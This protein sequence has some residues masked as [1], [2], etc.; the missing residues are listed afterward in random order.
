[1]SSSSTRRRN[2]RG[3]KKRNASSDLRSFRKALSSQVPPSLSP[4][5]HT[6]YCEAIH[7]YTPL[8]STA[9][10]ASVTFTFNS[11]SL[12][13][14]ATASPIYSP[15]LAALGRVFEKFRVVAY[16]YKIEVIARAATGDGITII[17]NNAVTDYQTSSGNGANTVT[18][19]DPRT[20][21]FCV[22]AI[23]KPPCHSVKRAYFSMDT[24]MG[25]QTWR[26][27]GDFQGTFDANGAV[28]ADPTIL[29]YLSICSSLLSGAAWTASES[30]RFIVHLTQDVVFSEPR[31]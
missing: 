9:A 22:P 24:I 10:T 7:S 23:N 4:S 25:H 28:S 1:M 2:G 15:R 27:D 14:T 30:P 26:D 17:Q 31:V 16:R 5:N 20:Q 12:A 19:T 11:N 13:A 8:A 6:T 3:G 18:C 21:S 29:T